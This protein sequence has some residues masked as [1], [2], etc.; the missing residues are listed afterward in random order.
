MIES[1]SRRISGVTDDEYEDRYKKTDIKIRMMKMSARIFRRTGKSKALLILFSA[2]LAVSSA[3]A[4]QNSEL[5]DI[6]FTIPANM[7]SE[8]FNARRAVLDNEVFPQVRQGDRLLNERNYQ[9]AW[10][11]YDR[12]LKILDRSKIQGDLI[13]S[14]RSQIEARMVKARKGW[15]QSVFEQA[16]KIYL[17]ALVEKDSAKAI[18]GFRKAQDRALAAVS[19]YYGGGR[20]LPPAQREE[21]IRRDRGFYDS[22]QTF[23]TDCTKMEEAYNFR[24]ETS[25]ENIDPDYKNRQLEITT[26]LRQGEVYY[27]EGQFEKV[28]NTVERVLIL[29][30]HYDVSMDSLIAA[31]TVI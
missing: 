15:G 23:M 5:E 14:L 30:E 25:L 17:D 22:I 20:P 9:D 3:A 21:M 10:E 24:A 18:E 1:R 6:E 19:P 12:A 11:A 28:R 27:R 8:E 26:L 31:G 16:R 7:Q 4:Q 13:K 2:V 29:A